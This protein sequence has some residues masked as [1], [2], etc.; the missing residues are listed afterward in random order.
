M[1][2]VSKELLA[3]Y[4]S[5]AV[6]Y[7]TIDISNVQTWSLSSPESLLKLVRL[8]EIML[9]NELNKNMTT[10]LGRGEAL[11]DVWMKQESDLIQGLARAF[12]ERIC[13]ESIMSA[14]ANESTASVKQVLSKLARLF[15]HSLINENLGWYLSTALVSIETGKQVPALQRQLVKELSPY[16]MDLIEALGV[17]PWM[18]FAPIANDWKAY[19]ADDNRGEL[20]KPRL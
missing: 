15:A 10:K 8:R 4:Q 16:S 2:K 1:Q 13:L 3:A 17:K 20:I 9:L 6:S 7:P 18:V 11:F 12:G 5:K 19:N 14:I